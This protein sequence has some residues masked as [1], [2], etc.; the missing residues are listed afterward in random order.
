MRPLGGKRRTVDWKG[1]GVSCQNPAPPGLYP[2]SV[3]VKDRWV[4]S[5]E[6]VLNVLIECQR[7]GPG[8]P[9]SLP[10]TVGDFT[11]TTSMVALGEK[12]CMDSW[13]GQLSCCGLGQEPF[14]GSC[15]PIQHC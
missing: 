1:R 11:P 4:D 9:S 14:F 5:H 7:Y 2:S 10:S 3:S 8:K 13:I 6:Q 15:G 12:L